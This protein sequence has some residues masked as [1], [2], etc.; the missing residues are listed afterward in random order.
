MQSQ[1]FHVD[2]NFDVDLSVMRQGVTTCVKESAIL[3]VGRCVH[4]E[5][6]KAFMNDKG[7]H[8]DEA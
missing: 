7:V 6:L 2:L 1:T 5:I 4:V 8:F 3:H